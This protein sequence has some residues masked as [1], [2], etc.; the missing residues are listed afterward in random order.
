MHQR[1]AGFER[2]MVRTTGGPAPVARIAFM[3]RAEDALHAAL[4]GW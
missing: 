3:Q 4:A 1:L 2:E